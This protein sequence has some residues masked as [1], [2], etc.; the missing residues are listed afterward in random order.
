MESK[1]SNLETE[2]N[3]FRHFSLRREYL[4]RRTNGNYGLPWLVLF[5]VIIS[6]SAETS[7]SAPDVTKAFPETE[8]ATRVVPKFTYPNPV[9]NLVVKAEVYNASR[10][11]LQLVVSWN[12]PTAGR[13]PTGYNLHVA[14]TNTNIENCNMLSYYKHINDKNATNTSIPDYIDVVNDFWVS[15]G[16]TYKIV[17]ESNPHDGKTNTSLKYTVPECIEDVCSCHHES[18]LP[19]PTDLLAHVIGPHSVNITWS[20]PPYRNIDTKTPINVTKFII[21]FGHQVFK[22]RRFYN[23]SPV[24]DLMYSG[25]RDFSSRHDLLIEPPSDLRPN[26]TYMAQVS[27][28]DNRGCKGHSTNVTFTLPVSTSKE[29]NQTSWVLVTVLPVLSFVVVSILAM[30]MVWQRCGGWIRR[31]LGEGRLQPIHSWRGVYK[32]VS[33]DSS[34]TRISRPFPTLQETNVI[35]VEKEI[36]DA[37]ARGDADIFEVSYT[38]LDLGRQI[39]KGAFGRVYL[40]RADAIAGIPGYT[41]V[42]VKKLKHKAT[43]D[44]VDEFQL[45]IAMMKR[46]GRHPN[47]VTMLGCCTLKQP[48]C[49]IMEY[50]PCGDLLQYLR[51]LRVEYERRTGS[52]L[53]ITS[54]MHRPIPRY[55]DL[56]HPST[57]SDASYVQPE[58]H[59][60]TTSTSRPSITETEWSLLSNDGPPLT[61]I[62]LATRRLEYVLDPKE[63]QSFAIQIAR[64]MAHLEHKQ[65][66]HR[67][68]A[69]RNVLIDENKTLKISD[70]G[71]SRSGIYINTKRKKVPLRWLS[72]EAMRDNLYS[73]KSDVWAYAI[74]LWEI[75]TLGGFPYPT[76]SDMDLLSFLLEGKR[77]E[78][79]DNCSDELYS[80]MLQC[81]SHSSDMR[82]SFEEIVKH[83]NSIMCR[84]RVYVDFTTLKP[85]YNFPPTEQQPQVPPNVKPTK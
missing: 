7:S 25:N 15:P 77:L 84:K 42:A 40:A 28:V 39:G 2:V 62:E 56:Q 70:F 38:R 66:T 13:R 73:S 29:T 18:W 32:A 34:T 6:A 37:K 24:G 5:S 36:V 14:P 81:W 23:M 82:P 19:K 54:T 17:V 50:V 75:G 83:L 64:G 69:A 48:L 85:D 44:E 63:L 4:S 43:P 26:V 22:E 60:T 10:R 47:V 21:Y 52:A 80:L 67:D 53:A 72:V 20:F 46:V 76:I 31:K 12:P 11:L 27:A 49:M 65:I 57:D 74:V 30:A 33:I 58:N 61:P 55:V 41:T 45:E 79:P 78:K 51:Q 8:T 9:T 71:L 1:S 59:M 35:Y 16:C 68:L 3:N